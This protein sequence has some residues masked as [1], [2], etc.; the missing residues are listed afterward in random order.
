MAM[1]GQGKEAQQIMDRLLREKSRQGVLIAPSLIEG[2]LLF[3]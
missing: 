2:V 3:R 1:N